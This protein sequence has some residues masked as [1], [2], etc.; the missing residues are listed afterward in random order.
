MEIDFF[1]LRATYSFFDPNCA[2]AYFG[3]GGA[4][5]ILGDQK[6]SEADMK[7]ALDLDPSLKKYLE[8]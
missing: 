8:D 3:R 4:T 6:G 7:K 1:T 5:G 2:A